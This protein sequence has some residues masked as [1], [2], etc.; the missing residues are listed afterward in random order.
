MY[1][2]MNKFRIV[3]GKEKDFEEVWRGRDTYISVGIVPYGT[4]P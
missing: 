3:L 4:R 2:A 1:I